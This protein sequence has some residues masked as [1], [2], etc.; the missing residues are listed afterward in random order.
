MFV[1]DVDFSVGSGTQLT[2]FSRFPIADVLWT[3]AMAINVY[4][5]VYR[6]YDVTSLRRLEWRYMIV[7]TTVTFIPAVTLL[8]IRT[9]DK[10]PMYGSVTVSIY[11]L[12]NLQNPIL[13]LDSN[14]F[15]APSPRNGSYSASSSTTCPFG[16]SSLLSLSHHS[17][18]P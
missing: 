2:P 17:P 3:L 9:D 8:F 10:G 12:F 1:F 4:L 14:S 11:P 5:I 6:S 15:G 18:N 13:T 7:I 16:M